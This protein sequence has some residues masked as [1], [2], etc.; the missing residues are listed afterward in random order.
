MPDPIIESGARRPLAGVR[1]NERTAARRLS[2]HAPLRS[3]RPH[4]CRASQRSKPISAQDR[5]S[6]FRE[7]YL[8][9]RKLRRSPSCATCTHGRGFEGAPVRHL[10]AGRRHGV[11]VRSESRT[12]SAGARSTA[13]R[14]RLAGDLKTKL[15]ETKTN[16]RADGFSRPFIAHGFSANLPPSGAVP[17]FCQQVAAP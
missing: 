7:P 6:S 9:A 2:E 15:L 5:A 13:T 3:A 11:A 4:W 10:F 12:Q 1:G 8:R 14:C 17:R 16:A